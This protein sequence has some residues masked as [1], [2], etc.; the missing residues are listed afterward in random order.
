MEHEQIY[1][2]WFSLRWTLSWICAAPQIHPKIKDWPID[3]PEGTSNP[4]SHTF[5]VAGATRR[6]PMVPQIQ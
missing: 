5:S 2:G 6:H 3:R 4:R 1:A